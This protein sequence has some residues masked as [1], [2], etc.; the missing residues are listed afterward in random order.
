MSPVHL[1]YRAARGALRHAGRLL[2]NERIQRRPV[3]VFSSRA[4]ILSPLSPLT[5]VRLYALHS[6]PSVQAKKAA[7]KKKA[8]KKV[9]PKKAPK[10]GTRTLGNARFT[11]ISTQTIYSLPLK[12]V[13][14]VFPPSRAN[15]LGAPLA[16][17]TVPPP[18][19][20]LCSPQPPAFHACD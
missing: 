20:C 5:H 18:R 2:Y 3:L 7:P 17:H 6:R 12:F 13:K 9:A 10:K 11:L 19:S 8:P 1:D 14:T 4:R 16:L 15:F